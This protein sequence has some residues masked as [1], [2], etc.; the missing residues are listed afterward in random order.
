[1][2][3]SDCNKCEVCCP[4]EARA[5]ITLVKS[6]V[7]FRVMHIISHDTRNEKKTKKN[8]QYQPVFISFVNFTIE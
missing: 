4:S 8:H 7:M 5:P 6:V 1:M 3:H 2:K